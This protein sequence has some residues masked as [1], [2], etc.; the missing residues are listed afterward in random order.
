MLP[1]ATAFVL[2]MGLGVISYRGIRNRMKYETWWVAH[3]YF[4]IAVALSFGHQV[5]L[6]T[7]DDDLT[8]GLRAAGGREH[9]SQHIAHEFHART[10]G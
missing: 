3:L 2:M 1:A 4:Y 7:D 6:G 9:P 10:D 5:A 8:D